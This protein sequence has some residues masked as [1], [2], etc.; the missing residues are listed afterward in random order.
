L[1]GGDIVVS[2]ANCYLVARFAMAD[3][4]AGNVM[5][6]RQLA[7]VVA[8]CLVGSDVVAQEALPTAATNATNVRAPYAQL[9]IMPEGSPPS[10]A[11]QPLV[12]SQYLQPPATSP[13][14]GSLTYV[15]PEGAAPPCCEVCGNPNECCSDCYR[16]GWTLAIDFAALEPRVTRG[17]FG[18]WPDEAAGA[19]RLTLGYEDPDGVGV[20]GIF[21]G[22]HDD[23]D[24]VSTDVELQMAAVHLDFYKS[25]VSPRHGEML[26]GFGGAYGSLEFRLPDVDDRSR[27]TGGGASVFAEGY[28]P[29]IRRP[30]WELAFVGQTR[31]SL[32]TGDWRDDTHSVVAPTDNDTM[33]VFEI[34]YGIEFR[35][36]FG[37][38]ADHYW[39]VRLM[40]EYQLWTSDWMS[41]FI[42]SG[43]GLT[44]TNLS[45]G[46]TW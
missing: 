18:S 17:E 40:D 21:W 39:F 44:G 32:L 42:G 5:A 14:P 22:L 4:N 30:R 35:R 26:L 28:Y 25:I 33:S 6:L 12:Q 41:N 10:A 15:P 36:R 3:L 29:G 9:P 27:F 23:V 38:L 2:A 19:G 7:I 24:A 45:L 34:S 43:V 1:A 11:L 8:F 16:S 46:F 20:R 31:M 37:R 13:P